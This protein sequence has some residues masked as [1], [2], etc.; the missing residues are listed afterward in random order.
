MKHFFIIYS[1][2]QT[3][4]KSVNASKAQNNLVITHLSSKSIIAINYNIQEQLFEI[5]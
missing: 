2:Y 4:S 3:K 1:Q 5:I